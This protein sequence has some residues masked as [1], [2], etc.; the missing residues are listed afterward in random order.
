MI[1]KGKGFGE[2]YFATTNT[3]D[4]AKLSPEERINT[5]L[6]LKSPNDVRF[7]SQFFEEDC[8]LHSFKQPTPGTSIATFRFRVERFYCNGAGN[9]HG[10]AQALI[11]DHLTS[12]AVQATGEVGGWIVPGVSRSL[13][14]TYLRPAPEGCVVLCECEVMSTGKRLA[15][16]RGI[17]KREDNGA[18]I[19]T[20]EHD[21]AFTGTPKI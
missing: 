10:G 5:V 11:F 18:I 17:M 3:P 20:C 6:A 2:Q 7:L 4:F 8:K 14:C 13:N 19:S 15:L 1:S 21:K 16:M 9:L 12:L